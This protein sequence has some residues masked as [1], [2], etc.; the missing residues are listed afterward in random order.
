MLLLGAVVGGRSSSSLSGPSGWQGL[1]PAW[2]Q[3]TL[4]CASQN[5]RT[6]CT[7]PGPGS[8]HSS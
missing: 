8:R 2:P 7:S 6:S 4:P 3:P 1:A 5:C